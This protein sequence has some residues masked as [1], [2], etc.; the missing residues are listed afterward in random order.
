MNCWHLASGGCVHFFI[1]LITR[2]EETVSGPWTHLW[3]VYVI[4]FFITPCCWFLLSY[5]FFFCHFLW[6]PDECEWYRG[7]KSSMCCALT[8]VQPL[9]IS[10]PRSKSF[11]HTLQ[12]AQEQFLFFY[13]TPPL[14]LAILIFFNQSLIWN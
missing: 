13:I 3:V 9:P 11:I 4:F 12:L 8:F 5:I 7:N 14:I 10:F 1:Y 2:E 6:Y